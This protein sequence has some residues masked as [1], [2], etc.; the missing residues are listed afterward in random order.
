M[1]RT[2]QSRF[3]GK[4]TSSK[5]TP[6]TR[7]KMWSE[8]DRVS[9]RRMRMVTTES[10]RSASSRAGV[11]VF[12][13]ALERESRPRTRRP[14]YITTPTTTT[15]GWRFVTESSWTLWHIGGSRQGH[16]RYTSASTKEG[17]GWPDKRPT[18]HD[19]T[20]RKDND[21]TKVMKKRTVK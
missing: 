5:R 3:V 4:R 6:T 9:W 20:R 18:R 12:S 19:S 16:P 15:K 14:H 8:S 10:L 2:C 17:R 13:V 21:E 11:W 7:R 1:K